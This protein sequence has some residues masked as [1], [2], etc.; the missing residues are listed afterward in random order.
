MQRNLRVSIDQTTW[1]GTGLQPSFPTTF[2]NGVQTHALNIPAM[3]LMI[4]YLTTPT[5]ST[6]VSLSEFWAWVRYLAAIATQADL[7]LTKSFWELDAHQKTILSDD[8]GMGV[9]LHWLWGKLDF[10]RVVDGRYFMQRIASSL[11]ATQARTAKRGPNKTPDFV[12]L[13]NYGKWHV[14]ECKGTQS[15]AKY[16]LKQLGVKGPPSTG[17]I[18][19][20]CSIQFPSGYTGQR[21][22]CGLSIGVEG[23]AGS[24]LEIIDPKSEKPFKLE[25]DQMNLAQDAANRGTMAK[26]LRMAGFEV[27]AESVASPFGPRAEDKPAR[28]KKAETARK[29]VTDERDKRSREEIR[30]IISRRQ[31]FEEDFW[32]RETVVALPREVLVDGQPVKRVIIQQGINRDALEELEQKPSVEDLVDNGDAI[33]WVGLMSDGDSV[34]EGHDQS[35]TMRIGSIF[36]LAIHLD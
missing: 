7:S 15:G 27:T 19:Q 9:P 16:S 20:K 25:K 2:Q 34:V 3:L 22:V 1:P 11:N 12:A 13:D 24:V 35:A 33:K 10:I 29:K 4:G 30:G 6:G 8:F 36:R 21:L 28:T 32:G 5:S 26:A 17:G 23:G 14:I 31:T 18:A